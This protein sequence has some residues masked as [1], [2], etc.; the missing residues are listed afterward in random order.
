MCA[1]DLADGRALVLHRYDR[2]AIKQHRCDECGRVIEVGETYRNECT[3]FDGSKETHKT[4][5]HCKECKAW[6][7]DQCGGYVYGEVQA[8]IVGHWQEYSGDWPKEWSDLRRAAAGIAAQ[9]RRK[10][11]RMWPIPFP[12]K[13]QTNAN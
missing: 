5:A 6:L 2:K 10:D 4:C 1:I 13:E 3:L 12:P 8:E 11:G 9:W 7:I